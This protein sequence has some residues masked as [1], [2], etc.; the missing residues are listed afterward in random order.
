MS[1]VLFD[2]LSQKVVGLNRPASPFE[3]SVSFPF[4]LTLAKR[5]SVRGEEVQKTDEQGNLLFMSNV[6]TDDVGNIVSF[7]ET[8][9]E[10]EVLETEDQTHTYTTVNDE[11]EEEELTVTSQVPTKTEKREPV[12]VMEPVYETVTFPESFSHFT[13][14]EIVAA[15]ETSL[16]QNN[17]MQLAYFNED[18]REEDFSTELTSHSADMGVGFIAVHPSG[19]VRTE[20]LPL[21]ILTDRV[22]IYIE[23]QEGISVEIGTNATTFYELTQ[24]TAFFPEPVDEV[25]VRFTNTAETKREIHSFGLLI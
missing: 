8:P 23:A 1:N 16:N 10:L 24:D 4:P 12:L 9:E 15:K 6:V 7:D 2:R 21:G 19:Q 11:G 14:E 17:L 25:Y 5:V 3:F 13:Y 18:M 22:K 20:K